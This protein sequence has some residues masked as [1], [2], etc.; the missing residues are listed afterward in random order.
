MAGAAAKNSGKNATK[1]RA[2]GMVMIPIG[3][4]W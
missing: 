1:R 4:E 3:T 2:R